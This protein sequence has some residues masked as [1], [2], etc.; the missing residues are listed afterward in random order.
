MHWSHMWADF[1]DT[2]TT[3]PSLHFT[4]LRLL[5]RFRRPSSPTSSFL[6][7]GFLR[8]GDLPSLAA[9]A[10]S[11]LG[12]V[13]LFVAAAALVVSASAGSAWLAA[14]LVCSCTSMSAMFRL[15]LGLLREPFTAAHSTLTPGMCVVCVCVCSPP[16]FFAA[17]C[18]GLAGQGTPNHKFVVWGRTR[19]A[20]AAAPDFCGG[21]R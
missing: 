14:T 21:M 15:L 2:L 4:R 10:P 5:F 1:G 19:P 6:D 18:A 13:P 9:S 11:L 3:C 16:G 7:F 8:L 12:S 17:C 20:A